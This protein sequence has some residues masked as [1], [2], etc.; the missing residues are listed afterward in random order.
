MESTKKNIGN[1]VT[2]EVKSNGNA[3]SGEL[4]FTQIKVHH[5]VN[6]IGSAELQ[7]LCGDMASA[8]VPE[9]AAA[10]FIPGAEITISLGFDSENKEVF[11]GVVTSHRI[12][13][14][15]KMAQPML[16]IVECRSHAI[17]ATVV[18]CNNV[19]EKKSDSD[20]ISEVLKKDGLTVTVDAIA[21]KHPQMVQYYC[22]DWDFALSR[23]DASGLLV[24]TYGNKVEAKKP[25]FS[26]KEVTTVKFGT[27]LLSFDAQLL[28]EAQS[29]EADC[30]GWNAAEQ[31]IVTANA[32]APASN[33][34]GNLTVDDLAKTTNTDKICLQNDACDNADILKA[35]GT[36]QLLKSELSRFQGSFSIY[37]FADV[38]PC[39]IV[40]LE[41]MGA[42]FNGNVFV[43]SVTHL[44]KPGIWTTEVGMGISPLNITQRTDV[45][46][47]PASGFLPGIEGL[48]IG[49]VQKL[50]DDPQSG[51][52]IQVK[53]PL[54]NVKENLVWA[55]LLQFAASNGSGCHFVPSV[56]DEV[57]LGFINNDPN[58][59]VIVGSLYSAKHPAL[60]EYDDKNYKRAIVS[61]EKL[62]V[63]LD[64][65]TK[66]VQIFTPGGNKVQI[67]DK[68][69]HILLTDQ[70]GN[71]VELSKDG[72]TLSTSK[73]L[74]IDAQDIKMTA[75]KDVIISTSAGD[76]N[77][78]GKNVKL[79]AN[80]NAKMSSS[81]ATEVSS[82]LN[83]TVKGTLVKIN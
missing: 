68:E 81:L 75:K 6:R 26:T 24:T 78:K 69:K 56:G 38:K 65:E 76:V 57:A 50:N 31:N 11:S 35:W 54:L 44:Y 40:K 1:P 66:Q 73:T 9:S 5:E 10:D 14:P 28:A 41:G 71:K 33:S 16:L 49:V 58:M 63:E 62:T 45:V 21:T 67:C 36:S 8:D 37:G 55:R 39:T 4:R 29:A 77:V 7:L 60:Y 82:S 80:M 52:R 59:A 46:T 18:R 72:I 43:G 22:T 74:Q 15:K 27:D 17:S 20:I 79:K 34:Q 47:P 3:V 19:F 13:L 48:H 32:K 42:R 12:R 61:P 25:D 53:I 30:I 23:A 64:D 51:F 83:M 2:F 70:N